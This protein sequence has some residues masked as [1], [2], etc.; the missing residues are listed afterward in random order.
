MRAN[1][2]RVQFLLSERETAR[3][4]VQAVLELSEMLTRHQ[5]DSREPLQCLQ[6]PV[7]HEPGLALIFVYAQARLEVQLRYASSR[8]S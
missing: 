7:T 3:E 5:V 8:P 2:R 4:T 1:R 6:T